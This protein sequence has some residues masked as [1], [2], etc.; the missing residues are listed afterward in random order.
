MVGHELLADTV[1]NTPGQLFGA[2]PQALSLFSNAVVSDESGNYEARDAAL[3]SILDPTKY[4]PLSARR[5]NSIE[6]LRLTV[7]GQRLANK[8]KSDEITTNKQL[9]TWV[10]INVAAH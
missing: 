9:A 10:A 7:R 5:G 4:G 8:I 2:T 1:R 3:D 6:D